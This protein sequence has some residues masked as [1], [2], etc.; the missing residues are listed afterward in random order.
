MKHELAEAIAVLKAQGIE[1]AVDPSG[2]HADVYVAKFSSGQEYEFLAAGI[3]KQKAEG[4]LTAAGLE[5]ESRKSG[6]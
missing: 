6:K 3:L 5:E 4:K 1:V 2:E